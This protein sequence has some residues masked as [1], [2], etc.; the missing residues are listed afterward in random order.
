[1]AFT[2]VYVPLFLTQGNQLLCCDILC[3]GHLGTTHGLVCRS[4]QEN[5]LPYK[6]HRI[7]CDCAF[8]VGLHTTVLMASVLSRLSEYGLFPLLEWFFNLHPII[9]NPDLRA[10]EGEEL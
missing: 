3:G 2:F 6:D 10:L 9:G 7:L 1:M 5:S 8:S 4:E